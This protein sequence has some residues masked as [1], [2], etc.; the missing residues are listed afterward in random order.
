MEIYNSQYAHSAHNVAAPHF[1]GASLK[2]TTETNRGG[3]VSQG[4]DVRLSR[5]AQQL[6][7]SETASQASAGSAPRL[8]LINSVRAQIAA[9]TYDT[10]EKMSVA[11]QRMLEGF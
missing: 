7:Q 11:F 5:E 4:D 6:S 10:P 9:G 2:S 1:R 3:S 8:D